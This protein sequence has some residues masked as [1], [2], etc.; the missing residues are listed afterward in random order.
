MRD[1]VALYFFCCAGSSAALAVAFWLRGKQM[2][3]RGSDALPMRR[4]CARRIV[5]N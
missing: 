4:F 5:N 2:G 1:G 3:R